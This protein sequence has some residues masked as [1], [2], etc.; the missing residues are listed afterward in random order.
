MYYLVTEMCPHTHISATKWCIVVYR[1]GALWDSCN[2]SII[3][4]R[5]WLLAE[6]NVS[7][8]ITWLWTVCYRIDHAIACY[9]FLLPCI[10]LHLIYFYLQGHICHCKEF[11]LS[12][13]SSEIW[14]WPT[15]SIC[16]P[17]TLTEKELSWSLIRCAAWVAAH[18][19][20]NLLLQ[21]YI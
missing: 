1:T 15:I 18:I 6:K 3:R 13:D 9:S 16:S 11:C 7:S 20:T 21:E 19:A 2:R 17:E 12:N 4:F 8:W 14:M 10:V 5:I